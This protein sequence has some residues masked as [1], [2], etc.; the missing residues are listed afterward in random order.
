MDVVILRDAA[1]VAEHGAGM[2]RRVIA[3]KSKAVF[4]L[5]TGKTP[6][7]LYA[8]LAA[9]C[10]AGRIS[11]RDATTFNLDEYLGIEPGNAQSYRACMRRDLF[12]RID[13]D[14]A[15]TFLPEC[16]DGE[17]PLAVGPRYEQQIDACGGID[18]QLLGIGANGHIGFN[19]PTS[20]LN[21]RTRIKTLTK[22]T[23]EANRRHFEDAGSQP[24]LAIT[25]GI[26]T[27]MDAREILLLAT[28]ATKAEAVRQAVEGPVTAMCPASILQMHERVTVLLDSAAAAALGR[29]DY[30]AWV[31]EQKRRLLV[32]R[33]DG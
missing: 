27:I 16:A 32:G 10:A 26:A 5:A 25:M 22:E 4:G 9:D 17:D 31:Q 24:E 33:E 15:N 30:Y 13:I 20:S 12:E 2:F 14:P 8:R 11:F 3:G 21:S 23:I 1:A 28:G 18:L 6:Q 19:E 7:P 29:R